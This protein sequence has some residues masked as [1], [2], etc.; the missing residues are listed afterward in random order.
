MVRSGYARRRAPTQRGREARSSCPFPPL[1]GCALKAKLA[2]AF[3]QQ[4]LFC[5]SGT[6]HNGGT[7]I[8][9]EGRWVLSVEPEVESPFSFIVSFSFSLL[10]AMAAPP[11]HAPSSPLSIAC[12]CPQGWTGDICSIPCEGD[13]CKV[14]NTCRH[15]GTYGQLTE[16]CYCDEPWTGSECQ[17]YDY[18][19]VAAKDNG[20]YVCEHEVCQLRSVAAWWPGEGRRR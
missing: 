11:A 10:M 1:G 19:D 2:V 5:L 14:E 15:G 17:E 6:C 3:V 12:E 8:A 7:C 16:Q 20:G 13:G 18:C 9:A 4:S